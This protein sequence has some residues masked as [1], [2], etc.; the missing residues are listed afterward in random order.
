MK[1]MWLSQ[2]AAHLCVRLKLW[3][4]TALFREEATSLQDNND[5]DLGAGTLTGWPFS[6]WTDCQQLWRIP[7]FSHC[8]HDRGSKKAKKMYLQSLYKH[9]LSGWWQFKCLGWCQHTHALLGP[10]VECNSVYL[11]KYFN[12]NLRDFYFQFLFMSLATSLHCI[13]KYCTPQHDFTDLDL[14]YKLF[15]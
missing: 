14:T 1:G 3:W 5:D 10:L 7:L 15:V 6:S 13:G 2:S 11:L 4:E 9:F 12:P 8:C